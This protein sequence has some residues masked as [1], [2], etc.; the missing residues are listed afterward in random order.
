[1]RILLQ[2]STSGVKTYHPFAIRIKE[3]LPD[4]VFGIASGA[5]VAMEFIKK[6][7]DIDYWMFEDDSMDV[8]KNEIDF[9]ELRKFEETLPNKSLWQV[10]ATDRVIGRAY[11]YGI[12]SYYNKQKSNRSYVLSE[13]SK[14]L[15]RYEQIFDEFKPDIFMPAMAM[16]DVG[17]TIIKQ[18]CDKHKVHYVLPDTLRIQNYCCFTDTPQIV[19]PIIDETYKKTIQGLDKDDL[20]PA[21]KL[22]NELVSESDL[23]NIYDRKMKKVDFNIF[24]FIRMILVALFLCTKILF[25]RAFF[26]DLKNSLYKIRALILL[27]FQ[28]IKW[29]SNNLGTVLDKDQ[30]YMYYPL[31]INPEYSTLT[32]GTMF[33]NQLTVIE[34]LAKSIPADWIVYVKEHPAMINEVVRS[35]FFYNRI[36]E[37]PNVEFAP[38]YSD[39]DILIDNAEM[40]AVING[41]TGWEAILRGKPVVT[42]SDYMFDAMG[43]SSKCTDLE[44]LSIKIHDEVNRINKMNK[45][46][47]KRR[48]LTF[49]SAVINCGF[50]ISYPYQFFYAH[51]DADKEYQLCGQELA[52]GFVKYLK[53]LQN[54]KNISFEI[55]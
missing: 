21:K 47:R 55:Y 31:H 7:N 37:L 43:L 11:L 13:F 29:D 2:I 12:E 1:M 30:K 26:R 50:W 19:F 10:I 16:G 54:E 15:K 46:E 49:L 17:V 52:A 40:I 3:I 28:K 48:I 42:F 14:K 18:L 6:Q 9:E 51:S 36:Q 35:K 38:P 45:E 53:Y 25:S 41:T 22:Y 23:P 34:A 4:T 20:K 8:C 27:A 32:Q 39:T 33:G 24:I 5:N 44:K